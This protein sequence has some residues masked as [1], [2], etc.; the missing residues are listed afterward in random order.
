MQWKANIFVES[1]KKVLKRSVK[2]FEKLSNNSGY[3]LV[4][5]AVYGLLALAFFV[6][7]PSCATMKPTEIQKVRTE[8]KSNVTE[9]LRELPKPDDKIVAA[10][11]GFRDQTGQYKPSENIS[12]STAVTQGA[13]SILIKSLEESG[14]FTPIERASISNLLNERRIIRSSRQENNDPTKLR[15]L[16]FAGVLL[17]GGII[18]YESNVLTGGLGARFLGMGASGEY[19]KDEVTIYLR[20]VSTQS[21]RILK[22]VRTTKSILSKKIQAGVFRYVGADRLLESEAGITFNEP[23]TMAVTAAIDAAVRKLIIAGVDANLWKPAD[24][25]AFNEYKANHQFAAVYKDRS[26]YIDNYGMTHRPSL[27]NG[28]ML[29]TNFTYGSYIG[30]Y[31]NSLG[32]T[33]LL[34]QVEGF[35]SPSFSIKASYQRSVIG[36][37]DIFEHPVNNFDLLFNAYMTPDFKF[38]PYI[39]AGGG[40]AIVGGVPKSSKSALPTFTAEAGLDY[41]INNYIG[42]RVGLNYRY[43]LDGSLDNVSVGSIKDQQWSIITGITLF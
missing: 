25:Q 20:V 21:G 9:S 22:T 23:A 16:L 27:R 32:S 38:S 2:L 17:E 10:V 19:R 28:F 40:A 6:F 42:F 31:D 8:V 5:P 26:A 12:Y 29:N 11:Y 18:G 13:T 37:K 15:P 33:G 41:R 1:M 34:L 30:N 14:W 24:M 36:A 43:L 4:S 35:L 7:V 39:S 3:A